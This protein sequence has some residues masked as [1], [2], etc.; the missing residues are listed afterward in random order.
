MAEEPQT[1]P[2]PPTTDGG[3]TLQ[4]PDVCGFQMSPLM[5]PGMVPFQ[6]SDSDEH[7]SGIYAIPYLPYMGPMAGI[8]P[9]MLIPLKYNIP[10]RQV[11]G[12][13][14]DEHGQEVRQQHGPQRQ[15]V[16][17]R[18]HFAF[19]LDLGLIIKLA[20][21]VF[22]LSQD[23]SPQKLVLLV[24]FALLVYLYQTGVFAPFIRWLQ[25][26]GAPPRQEAPMQPQNGPPVGH[27]GQNNPQRGE[28]YG[29][30]NQNQNQPAENQGPP[31]ANENHPEPEGHGNNFW[32]VV[33]EIQMFVVG[34]L[35]SLLPGFHNND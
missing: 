20:A 1:D 29:V 5:F 6:S 28:I 10:T 12:G 18:F 26:A 19:Q 2:T 16:V 32:R 4:V 33:K 22:L 7:G 17:R 21:M 30:N 9:T 8:S 35:T 14:T 24:L 11:S 3:L 13:A 31:D 27:D 23:G 15:V 25:Q 34:F